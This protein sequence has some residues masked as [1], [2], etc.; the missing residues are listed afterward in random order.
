M[1]SRLESEQDIKDFILGLNLSVQESP[2]DQGWGFTK[3]GDQWYVYMFDL[4]EVCRKHV[5]VYDAIQKWDDLCIMRRDARDEFI[6]C[7]EGKTRI[8]L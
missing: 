6:C 3:N 8:S 2:A 1:Y 4:D 5:D 7:I